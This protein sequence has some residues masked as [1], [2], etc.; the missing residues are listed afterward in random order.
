M[1]QKLR[2]ESLV[3]PFYS[4]QIS[5]WMLENRGRGGGTRQMY[6]SYIS[7]ILVLRILRCLC[8]LLIS[9]ILASKITAVQ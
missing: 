3:F 6:S 8:R 7:G 9:C 1:T 5:S 4:T 2:N